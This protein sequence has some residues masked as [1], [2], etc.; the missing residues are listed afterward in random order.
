MI[1]GQFIWLYSVSPLLTLLFL[2]GAL[3]YLVTQRSRNPAGARLAIGGVVLMMLDLVFSAIT[4]MILPFHFV[5]NS[6]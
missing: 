3:V 5:R 6:R 2:I 1:T 4:P